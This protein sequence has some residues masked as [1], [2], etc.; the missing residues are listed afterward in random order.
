MNPLLTRYCRSAAAS[1]AVGALVAAPAAFAQSL[2]RSYVASQDVYKVA[3]ENEQWRI[4]SIKWKP[5][6]K[7]EMH[8]HP[9]AG[10][11]VIDDCSLRATF[12]DGTIRDTTPRAGQSGFQQAVPAHSVQ[13]IGSTDCRM[14][15]FEPK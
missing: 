4:I 7:D 3:A 12:P 10:V 11:Y 13:N 5:G 8:S 1:I 2:P 14:V 6:Q 9:A 15:M